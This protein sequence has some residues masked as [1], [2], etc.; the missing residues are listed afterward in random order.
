MKWSSHCTES[1]GYYV[2]TQRSFCLVHTIQI[3]WVVSP[4]LM[5]K[6]VFFFCFFASFHCNSTIFSLQLLCC[7]WPHDFSGSVAGAEYAFTFVYT[8]I[9]LLLIPFSFQSIRYAGNSVSVDE[10]CSRSCHFVRCTKCV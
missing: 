2:R 1:V 4:M 10:L 3:R 8:H 9:F 7:C 5:A 6:T